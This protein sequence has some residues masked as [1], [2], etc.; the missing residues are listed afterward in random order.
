MKVG[1]VVFDGF[2]ELDAVGPYEVLRAASQ[3][4]AAIEARLVTLRHTSTVKGSH[5]LTIVPEGTLDEPLDWIIVPGGIWAAHGPVG[6]WGEIERGELPRALAR[7]R[8]SGQSMASVCTGAMLLSAAG[9]TRDRPAVTHHL[10]TEALAKEGA[11]VVDARVVDDGDLITAGGVT[12]GID[13]AL[14]FVERHF[15]SDLA[16]RIASQMEYT[17]VGP[18]WSSTSRT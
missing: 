10:A 9:I 13:F 6:A 1:I 18:I 3:H 2:D 16:N 8:E 14:W 7:L 17:R 11:R 4:G 5:G 12:S 15:G